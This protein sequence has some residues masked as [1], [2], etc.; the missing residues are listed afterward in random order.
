MWGLSRTFQFRSQPLLSV[1]PL[2]HALFKSRC[3][4]WKGLLW[5]CQGDSKVHTASSTFSS[6]HFG[7]RRG[8]N[9]KCNEPGC[10]NNGNVTLALNP[11]AVLILK[12]KKNTSLYITHL[13]DISLYYCRCYWKY[14]SIQKQIIQQHLIRDNSTHLRN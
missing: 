2:F 5:V 4:Q 14:I 10:G 1:A 7:L 3:R 8:T 13:Y 6:S 11:K 9:W 12:W